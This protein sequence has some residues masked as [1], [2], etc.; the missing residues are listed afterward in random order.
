MRNHFNEDTAIAIRSFSIQI[1][2]LAE[3]AAPL[4]NNPD[5]P[6]IDNVNARVLHYEHMCPCSAA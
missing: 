4:R 2:Y 3:G 1:K 6:E 5:I